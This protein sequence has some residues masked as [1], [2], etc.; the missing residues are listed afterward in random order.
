MEL[1]VSSSQPILEVTLNKESSGLAAT[2]TETIATPKSLD[3]V[4]Q[5]SLHH[6]FVTWVIYAV[7]LELLKL[8]WAVIEYENLKLCALL[9]DKK[10]ILIV[11]SEL[12]IL[13]QELQEEL[14]KLRAWRPFNH[15][16]SNS[17]HSS[18]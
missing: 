12:T 7:V 5:I 18:L 17:A 4:K 9:L 3:S 8:I 15:R 10:P 14:Q 13:E 16:L 11:A 1:L 2:I 6:N